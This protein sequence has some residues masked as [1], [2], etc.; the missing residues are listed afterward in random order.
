MPKLLAEYPAKD[1]AGWIGNSVEVAQQSD[2]M[3][4]DDSFQRA[5][6][7]SGVGV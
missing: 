7:C 2:A 5:T 4:P 3:P 6:P 1:V